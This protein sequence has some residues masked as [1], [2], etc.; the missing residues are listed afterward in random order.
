MT[1][2]LDPYHLQ[3]TLPHMQWASMDHFSADDKLLARFLHMQI[4]TIK[5]WLRQNAEWSGSKLS[6]V[7][8]VDHLHK[9]LSAET[10]VIWCWVLWDQK[11][12]K[13]CQGGLANIVRP[14]F[15]RHI[16][17]PSH[18]LDNN[19]W[20]E[21]ICKHFNN[22]YLYTSV[23]STYPVACIPTQFVISIKPVEIIV[24]RVGVDAADQ[25]CKLHIRKQ[26]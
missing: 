3:Q 5:Y 19:K 1:G 2:L 21:A 10:A 9:Q 8:Y 13:Q 23:T 18:S 24:G 12:S 26:R 15:Q 11:C 22:I 7:K 20:T 25:V 17:S 6:I 14:I 16:Q 4:R